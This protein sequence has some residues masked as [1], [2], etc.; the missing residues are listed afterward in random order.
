MAPSLLSW[1]EY[2][3]DW[4]GLHGGYD[5]RYG[6][7]WV[8][9]W[10]RGSYAVGY[11]LA[12]IG[13]TPAAVTVAGLVLSAL[14]PV[15]AGVGPGVLAAAAGLV[16]L[17]AVADS[18]DGAVAVLTGRASRWGY[19]YDSVA[20]RLGEACWLLALW[21]VGGPGW[22]VV[23]CGGLSWL[24]EYLRARA[25]GAGLAEV[26]VVSVAERPTRIIVAVL[27]LLAGWAAGRLPVG[28]SVP[29]AVAAGLAV[30][31]LLGL[32]GIGQLAA[33]VR[34]GLR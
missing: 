15:L 4:A 12:G 10:L 25:V 24:H 3:R 7:R 23:G 20:D 11:R 22:L 30:W 18:V 29:D 26:G 8:R 2:A 33:A 13:A 28:V 19:V 27:A 21:R 16:G 34:R 17:A 1:D 5:P 32:V 9:G 6:S 14:V 31:A